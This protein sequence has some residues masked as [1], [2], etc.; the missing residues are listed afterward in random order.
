MKKAVQEKAAEAVQEKESPKKQPAPKKPIL[1][2][3]AAK[4]A[5]AKSEEIYVQF[6]S[7]EW[8]T[9]DLVRQ[10]KEDY[11]AQGHRAAGQPGYKQPGRLKGQFLGQLG[12][13]PGVGGVLLDGGAN[14][15]VGGLHGTDHKLVHIS[16]P[17]AS[18][19][20]GSRRR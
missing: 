10:V 20:P 1:R 18:F 12:A 5:P 17:P 4:A 13:G 7:G 15:Q 2:K 11:A 19:C 3:K 14:F 8:R 16:G 6:G 9:D